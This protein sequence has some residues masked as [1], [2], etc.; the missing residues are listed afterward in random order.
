MLLVC[1]LLKSIFLLTQCPLFL[2]R[3]FAII[4][5]RNSPFTFTSP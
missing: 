1:L 2:N 4:S 3:T 5:V